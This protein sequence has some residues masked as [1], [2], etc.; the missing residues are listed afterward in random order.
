MVGRRADLETTWGLLET[1]GTPVVTAFRRGHLK[2][3]TRF[4]HLFLDVPEN[5][6]VCWDPLHARPSFLEDLTERPCKC[7]RLGR[8]GCGAAEAAA[9]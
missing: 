5:G 9:G 1:S 3:G 8:F 2:E 7:L 4:C 6:K